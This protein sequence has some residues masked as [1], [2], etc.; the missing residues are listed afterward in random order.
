MRECVVSP[1]CN[2]S[3]SSN[4]SFLLQLSK[5]IIKQLATKSFQYPLTDRSS[6]NFQEWCRT[7]L[8][9]LFQYPLTD[10]SSCNWCSSAHTK[11]NDNFQYP[12][13]DHSSCNHPA[14]L[15]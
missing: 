8:T 3:V 10:R 6:C 12:L 5:L 2:L 14:Y 4:G 7:V 15:W 13:T 11:K 1:R 9:I